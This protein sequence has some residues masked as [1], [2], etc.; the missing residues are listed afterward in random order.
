MPARSGSTT[1]PT[2]RSV[3]A[4]AGGHGA[5]VGVAVVPGVERAPLGEE[6]DR[7]GDLLVE[8]VSGSHRPSRV[9]GDEAGGADRGR[10]RR[11][12]P[13]PGAEVG[14]AEAR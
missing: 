8:V 6:R 14:G 5:A 3:G 10:A 11:R 1:T 9:D 4:A 2:V 7:A 13:G 12:A